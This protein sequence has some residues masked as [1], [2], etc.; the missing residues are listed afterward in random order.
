MDQLCIVT[1][2]G[3]IDKIYFDDKSDFQIGD[4]QI[5]RI[6]EELGV[7]FRFSVIPILR[8]DSL[9][10]TDA[11]RALLRS[12]ILAQDAAHVLVTHGTDTMVE[13]AHV[14]ADIPGKTIV[15]TGALNPARFRGSDA[16]FN[17]GT[18]VGAVQSLPPGVYIAMNGRIWDPSR[19]RKNVE[20]NRFEATG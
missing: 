16:E 6:L 12:T 7:A 2:G 14:L 11:D 9:H 13:T 18:A 19:V 8:K 10:I 3:T 4:P 20:A 1:T 15:L 17:V 5:G